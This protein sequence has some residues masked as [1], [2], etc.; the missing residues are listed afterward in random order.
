M[1]VVYFCITLI[2]IPVVIAVLTITIFPRRQFD[3]VSVVLKHRNVNEK[4][5]WEQF[6]SSAVGM[7]IYER[8]FMHWAF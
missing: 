4:T 1:I 8:I 2:L 7:G 5:P 3:Q 6:I